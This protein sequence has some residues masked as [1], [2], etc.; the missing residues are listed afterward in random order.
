MTRLNIVLLLLAIGCALGAV[1]S[2]HQAR[3]LFVAL[4]KEQERMKQLEV[5]F[6]Q[7]QL[8]VSTWARQA[9]IEKIA[10]SQLNM[11]ALS[12][13]RLQVL[14]SGAPEADK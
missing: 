7:L 14:V 5:E 3:K 12:P 2:Q 6:G 1:A 9:R 10:A 4:E 11:R 13:N 8:E